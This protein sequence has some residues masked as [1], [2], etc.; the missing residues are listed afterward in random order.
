M[1]ERHFEAA[2]ALEEAFRKKS[3]EKYQNYTI[4]KGSAGECEYCGEQSP[5][6]INSACAR[7]RDQYRLP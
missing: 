4:P 5:R 6:L 2:S 7:C 1:D 3:I